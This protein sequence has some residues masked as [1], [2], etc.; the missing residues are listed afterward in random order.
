MRP[1]PPADHL[2]HALV[3]ACIAAV[4]SLI[5]ALWY[6]PLPWMAAGAALAV[7]LAALLR[8]LYNRRRGGVWSWQD[9]GWTLGGAVPSLGALAAGAIGGA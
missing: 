6:A 7:V 1:L 2:T 4:V 9:I 8:E 5:L 3:G